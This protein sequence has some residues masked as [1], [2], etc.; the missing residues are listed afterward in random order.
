MNALVSIVITTKNEELNLSNCLK[1]IVEQTYKSIEIIVVDN[2][3]SDRT[4][5]VAQE[6]TDKIFDFGPERSAQRNL[7]MISVAEG[8]YVVYV[9]ADMLLT[10]NLVS[11]CVDAMREHKY[12]ALYI[13][14]IVLG[15][16]FFAKIRRFERLF[17][18]GTP[19]DATRFFLK[20]DFVKTGGF[21]EKLFRNG[22]G[23]DWDLDK[24]IR[25]IGEV[26]LLN[27]VSP[28]STVS[29]DAWMFKFADKH[30][31]RILDTWNGF[32]HNE[33][34]VRLLPYLRK[35]RYYAGGFE[36]YIKKWGSKD[37]DV[38]KQFGLTYRIFWIFIENKKWKSSLRHP[39]L[40]IATIALKILVG[41][42]T[43]DRWGR[44]KF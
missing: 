23:E 29:R 26:G 14:E 10:P 44:E 9:D 15:E 37:V 21:D 19:I 16:T 40:F 42:W 32:L 7:G 27:N 34:A 24:K 33:S 22:S 31:V 6:F 25:Q 43:V 20:S 18:D 1:S 11:V 30:G 8:E 35:K 39:V 13:P 38:Q 41:L 12:S 3:S 5:E 4:K 28:N 2:N 17:Y 36:G